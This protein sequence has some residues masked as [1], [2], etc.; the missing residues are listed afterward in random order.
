VIKC[1]R[2]TH[3]SLIV[4]ARLHPLDPEEYLRCLIRLVP[5]CPADR[6][7]ELTPLFWAQDARS[8]GRGPAR[9]SQK[10]TAIDIPADPLDTSAPAEQQRASS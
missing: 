10:S 3:D 7:L 6:M 8:A 1:A 4:S 2:N 5:M 9:S